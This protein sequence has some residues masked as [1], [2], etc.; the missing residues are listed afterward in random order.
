MGL[1]CCAHWTG[2]ASTYLF[3]FDIFGPLSF[4]PPMFLFGGLGQGKLIVPNAAAGI[5]SVNPKLAGSAFLGAS[6]NTG[7]DWG[8]FDSIC[9]RL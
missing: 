8:G 6:H 5:V 4:F 1:L 2:I 9:N 7:Y 3:E